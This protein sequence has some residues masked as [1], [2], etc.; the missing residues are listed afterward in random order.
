MADEHLR[1]LLLG[2]TGI[3]K[4]NV[5]KKVIAAAEDE[6]HRHVNFIDFE[7]DALPRARS[8][9]TNFAFLFGDV[10]DQARIWNEA[11]Q[12]V[13]TRLNELPA[14]E[15]CILSLH[16]VL[17]RGDAGTRSVI[18]VSAI[19][20]DFKPTLVVTLAVDI[21]NM[22]WRTE[23]RARGEFSRGRPTIEQLLEAR[24]AETL[25]GDLIS[26][27]SELERPARHVFISVNHPVEV[28]RD[29]I[30]FDSE[31]SYLS[32]PISAPRDLLKLGDAELMNGINEFHRCVYRE[33]KI[34]SRP[35]RVY[36]S[37]LSIDELPLKEAMSQQPEDISFDPAVSRWPLAA[38]WGDA[39]L[40]CDAEPPRCDIPRNQLSDAMGILETD[41]GW[42]DFRLVRQS[43][44]LG[45][46]CPK[47]PN[48]DRLSRGVEAEIRAAVEGV[49]KR[50]YIWQKPEWDPQNVVDNTIGTPGSMGMDVLQRQAQRVATL[51]EL[52]SRMLSV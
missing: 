32:F 26:H 24:R 50:I 10:A 39:P 4:T 48:R 6:F 3:G 12:H 33:Y 28:L 27:Q 52:A 49:D 34:R 23:E 17:V 14:N 36:I 5:A 21:F 46:Y 20:R 18:D 30:I 35:K 31:I 9:K 47:P 11:W 45:V 19:C 38:L 1:T 25:I 22:W 42:R 51:D 43:G 37:P 8:Y 7:N 29:I 40:L 13:R 44:S 15:P 41:V 2:P 16:G